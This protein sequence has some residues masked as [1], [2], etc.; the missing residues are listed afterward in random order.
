MKMDY[1]V[2]ME[3]VEG[4]G[5]RPRRFACLGALTLHT[6]EISGHVWD[7]NPDV[8]REDTVPHGSEKYLFLCMV[9]LCHVT[10]ITKSLKYKQ[11][12][13]YS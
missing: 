4:L 6:A 7:C 10:F 2:T 13:G 9:V 11:F 8:S 12:S 1:D 5:L 3:R